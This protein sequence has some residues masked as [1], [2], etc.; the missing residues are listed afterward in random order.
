MGWDWVL[1]AA[2]LPYTRIDE[3][4]VRAGRLRQTPVELLI[5]PRAT[6]MD[7]GLAGELAAMMRHQ[8]GEGHGESERQRGMLVLQAEAG[9]HAE[10]KPEPRVSG[11]QDAGDHPDAAHPEKRLE[12]IHGE[13]AVGHQNGGAEQNGGSGEKLGIASAAEFTRD[14]H[15]ERD[16]RGAGERGKDAQRPERSAHQQRDFRVNGDQ[17]GGIDVAPVE[18]AGHVE[19]IKFVAKVAVVADAGEEVQQQFG[20][21]ERGHDADGEAR[22]RPGRVC[23]AVR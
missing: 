6:A 15:G 1:Q 21:A 16:E 2:K 5:V 12:G 20:S 23:L 4:D 17:R 11:A 3:S 8:E 18:M 22:Q 9:E 14:E 19:V 7:D 13:E 10:P